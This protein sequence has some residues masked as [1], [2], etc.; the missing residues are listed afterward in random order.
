[1]LLWFGSP[2]VSQSRLKL[3]HVREHRKEYG[4]AISLDDY[5]KIDHPANR[6]DCLATIW[7]TERLQLMPGSIWHAI[8]RHYWP[9]SNAFYWNRL[10]MVTSSDAIRCLLRPNL[11]YRSTT[12]SS[13][14]IRR[15]IL[16]AIIDPGF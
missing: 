16:K 3:L 2:C 4:E 1:M 14:I 13:N 7:A 12:R 10:N 9:V 15:L 11:F 5:G 6:C 8:D